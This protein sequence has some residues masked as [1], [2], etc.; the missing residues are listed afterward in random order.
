MLR[1]TLFTC[2]TPFFRLVI[3]DVTSVFHA[4]GIQQG[5]MDMNLES[6]STETTIKVL[7]KTLASWITRYPMLMLVFYFTRGDR[8]FLKTPH[9]HTHRHISPILKF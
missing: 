1:M 6:C 4:R 5:W 9:I 8:N 7:I 2:L 3:K